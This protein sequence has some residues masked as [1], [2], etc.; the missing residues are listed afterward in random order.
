[1]AAC[2]TVKIIREGGEVVINKSDYDP[3]EHKLAGEK[4][5]KKKKAD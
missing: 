4:K 5:A 2:E 1:M 3:K